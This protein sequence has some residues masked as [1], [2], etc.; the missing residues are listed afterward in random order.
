[1]ASRVQA[2]F[3]DALIVHRLD[4]ETSGL[5]AMGRGATAQRQ[6]SILFLKRLVEKRYV[7]VVH[8]LLARDSGTIDLPLIADWPNRPRQKV[9]F[10]S[11]KPAV[12]HFR[13]VARD[14][15]TNRTR[16]E[17]NPITGRSHQLRMHM[18]ALGHPIVGDRLYACPEVAPLSPRL[19]LHAESLAFT[20]PLNGAEMRLHS[21]EPF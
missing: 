17:L 18:L 8:G 2:R 11:G 7:A 9:D 21:P 6:M 16:V 4:M 14:T 19:L 10:V 20:H 3:S 1:M 15:Q 13:V 12:T 5:L